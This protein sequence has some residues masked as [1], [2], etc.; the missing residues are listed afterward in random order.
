MVLSLFKLPTIEN[1][2]SNCG[3]EEGNV[4]QRYDR[5]FCNHTFKLAVFSS[6]T[7]RVKKTS[8]DICNLHMRGISCWC[9]E[10]VPRPRI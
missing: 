6:I 9:G 2:M 5:T 1:S 8:K 10:N 7:T 3:H 4:P